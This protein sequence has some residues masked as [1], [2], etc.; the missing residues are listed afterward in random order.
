HFGSAPCR[1]PAYAS[2]A[3]PRAPRS[4]RT[5]LRTLRHFPQVQ[6]PSFYQ[7]THTR[8]LDDHS[9][10]RPLGAL[11]D[12]S[13]SHYP[14]PRLSKQEQSTSGIEK[15]ERSAERSTYEPLS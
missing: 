9:R 4:T 12:P 11:L 2:V 10:R 7:P 3:S 15:R 8:V 14:Q 6:K 1:V 5:P 13:I